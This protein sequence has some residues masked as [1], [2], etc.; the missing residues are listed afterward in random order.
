MT[1]VAFLWHLHQPYY[2]DRRT[3]EHLLPW[4]RLHALK[5]Y[6]GMAEALR[7][8]PTMRATV[9]LVPSLLVQV[10]AFAE[11]RAREP[12]L[13]AG[14]T[15]VASLT[16]GQR[17]L[18][19][20]EGFHG[21][22]PTMVEPYPRYLTLQRLRGAATDDAAL[23][24][25]TYRFRDADWRDL[26][27][28][29][30]LAWVDPDWAM[31]DDRVQRLLKRGAHFTDE[32]VRMLRAV[33]LDLLRAVVPA[34]R[35]LH[36]S[37]QVELSTSPFYHPILPL[38]CDTD[39][40]RQTHPEAPALRHRFA[41]PDDADAQLRRATACHLRLFGDRPRGLWPSEGSVSDAVAALASADGFTWMATDEAI[42][43]RAT[44]GQF[45]RDA[46][47]RLVEDAARLYRP[48]TADTAAGPITVLFRDHVLSDRIGFVYASWAPE[49][50]ATDLVERIVDAGQR[51]TA[52]GVSEPVVVLCVDGENPW[53]HYQGG[54][55]SFLRALYEGCSAHPDLVPVQ[56]GDIP[57]QEA[58]PLPHVPAGSWIDGNFSI[59][60]GH[61]DD[62]R[63]WSQLAD[64]RQA[65]A[66]ASSTAQ[67]DTEDGARRRAL[68]DAY[69]ELL[70][71][72]GSDWCW[73]YGDDHSSDHDE[74][75]D[76]LYRRHVR[77]VYLALGEAVP[78]ELYR[79]NI[80]TRAVLDGRRPPTGLLAPRTDGRVSHYFEWVH[81]G[82]WT[83]SAASGTMH[84]VAAE[85]AVV[86]AIYYGVSET[87]LHLRVD[88]EGRAA[89]WM[90][91][92]MLSVVCAAPPNRTLR[93]VR[94]A[95][96]EI[97]CTW[98]GEHTAPFRGHAA[99]DDVFEV[100]CPLAEFGA[101]DAVAVTIE[102][103]HAGQHRHEHAPPSRPIVVA[104]PDASY[105]ARHWSA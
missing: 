23:R 2:E 64:A 42:L 18:L 48:W 95:A 59:W 81:A 28:W 21:H 70:I 77:N 43:A 47:G 7:Q 56:M 49:S 63:A 84:S 58:L 78:D 80:T 101:V 38:L 71:A 76:D 13:E 24:E 102:F 55:R 100:S 33:E 86:Q 52:A 85:R 54:G 9:N 36:A 12:L 1:R 72:E 17:L 51:A 89:I 50:A 44:G 15:P 25:A 75:F 27:I 34:W 8:V 87:A 16:D 82:V 30:K 3:G 60:I 96:G 99:A 39:V 104:L 74:A 11:E 29:Q 66:V 40:Y 83:P 103:V 45:T 35:A 26:Q 90:A 22:P 69:E 37:G 68:D 94:A 6:W 5:D 93:C 41:W 32:D 46:D 57:R 61:E 88:F 53:E 92:G 19:L 14:L 91:E 97:V 4:V 10:E 31:R 62:R 79:S 20:R 73:W 105:A 67:S 65:Y 98:L